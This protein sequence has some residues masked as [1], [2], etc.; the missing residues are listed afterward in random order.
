M[1]DNWNSILAPGTRWQD[2]YP[3]VTA[4]AKEIL[5]ADDFTGALGMTE[6]ARAV[7]GEDASN[8]TRGVV[9]KALRAGCRHELKDWH[10][11]EETPNPYRKGEVMHKYMF[12]AYVEPEPDQVCGFCGATEEHWRGDE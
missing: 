9:V 11:R 2:T 8:A 3:L 7:S 5:S 6:M 12:T 10:Y 4:R 1:T